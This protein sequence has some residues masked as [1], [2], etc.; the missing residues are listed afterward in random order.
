VISP[1]SSSSVV[2]V[3]RVAE[4]ILLTELHRAECL[5]LCW[6][7]A[8]KWDELHRAQSAAR[9][10][11]RFS[12]RCWWRFSILACY[13]APLG[14]RLATFRQ[15][16]LP[17]VT[18]GCPQK[19]KMW[20]SICYAM[21][22]G[23]LTMKMGPTVLGYMNTNWLYELKFTYIRIFFKSLL[24]SLYQAGRKGLPELST[25]STYILCP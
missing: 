11:W 19:C 12:Q 14:T 21:H 23:Y 13:S 3:R 2:T 6:R 1:Q 24:T 8:N 5:R 15:I 10:R 20:P 18:S 4:V 25:P 7:C 17:C 9:W 22:I 16:L